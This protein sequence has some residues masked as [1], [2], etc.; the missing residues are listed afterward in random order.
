MR[1]GRLLGLAMTTALV[2]APVQAQDQAPPPVRAE[3][4]ATVRGEAG[5][6]RPG[7]LRLFLDDTVL[8]KTLV[9]RL[10]WSAALDHREGAPG[11]WGTGA[12]A[13]GKRMAGRAGLVLAQAGVQHGTAAL[14]RVDPRGDQSR[15]ACTHPMKRAAHAITRTFVTR[16]QRG[17][18]RPNIPLVAGAAGGAAIARAWYPPNEGPGRDAARFA[19]MAVVG[20]AG[21]NLLQEFAPELK[22]LNPLRR[23][24]KPRNEPVPG[25]S[26]N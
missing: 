2:A 25:A 12:D 22:R 19:A 11:A 6:D 16:D 20:Q 23:K 21:T 5:P 15:C 18:T 8:S 3:D 9:P 4:S 24:P 10:A 13:Y 26:A 7:R 14:M 1:R 17:R